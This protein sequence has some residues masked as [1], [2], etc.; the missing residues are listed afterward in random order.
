MIF[1][2]DIAS[3]T[4]K[5]TVG[6]SKSLYNNFE[7]FK[8]KKLI[9]NLEGLISD[10]F[11]DNSNVPVLYNNPSIIKAL[12]TGEPPLLCLANNHILDIPDLFD[13]SI[14]LF[15]Q[16]NILTA[17]AGRSPREASMPAIFYYRNLKIYLFN[18]CWDFLLYNHKNPE[19]GIYISVID[20]NSMIKSVKEIKTNEPDSKIVI[21]LH[22]NL[23]LEV[24]P[25]PMHRQ[26]AKS[27]IDAGANVVTGSHSHCVQGGEK[28]KN[29]YIVYGLGNFFLPHNHFINGKLVYPEFS[30]LEL[31]LEWSPLTNSAICHW[32][33]YI[34]GGNSHG[35]EYLSSENFENSDTLAKLSPYRN[36]DDSTY[37]KFF[38]ES[39]RKKILVPVYRDY[40]NGKI[41]SLFTRFL[42]IRARFARLMARLNIINWQN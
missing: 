24:L 36:T 25:F 4:L 40:R 13:N 23:D 31:A 27:L 12:H 33:K 1:C 9:C 29:G 22:W 28:Y 6:F 5:T 34:V 30:S 35:L 32:F 20:E 14:N 3:P 39:R 37:L 10:D 26:F 11:Y 8:G 18:A 16:N 41:N 42:K 19:A 17:G 15:K 38:R 2:G 21:Y 7:V